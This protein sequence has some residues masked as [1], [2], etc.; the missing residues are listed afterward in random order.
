MGAGMTDE[1]LE[2]RPIRLEDI[3][4]RQVATGRI[5]VLS[6]RAAPFV[7]LWD[8]RT[9]KHMGQSHI[10]DRARDVYRICTNDTLEDLDGE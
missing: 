3:F 9:F 8:G 1:R 2:L 10:E 4:G 6:D 5:R 7:L